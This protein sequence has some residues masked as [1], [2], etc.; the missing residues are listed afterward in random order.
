MH[1]VDAVNELSERLL[2]SLVGI[3]SDMTS[4]D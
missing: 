3:A 1:N 4:A 2:L